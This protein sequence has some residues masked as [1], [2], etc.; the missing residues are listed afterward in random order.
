[1]NEV[2]IIFGTIV[3]LRRLRLG[4]LNKRKNWHSFP[5]LSLEWETPL[6]CANCLFVCSLAP[7]TMATVKMVVKPFQKWKKLGCI[8]LGIEASHEFYGIVDKF[9]LTNEID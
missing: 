3:Q 7:V 4:D 5:G 8:N 6:S 1:M 9:L 2:A